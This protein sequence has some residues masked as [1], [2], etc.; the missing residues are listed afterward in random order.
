MKWSEGEIKILKDGYENGKPPEKIAEELGRS[1]RAVISKASVMGISN[2]MRV[3]TEE[4]AKKLKEWYEVHTDSLDLELLSVEMGRTMPFL[5]RQAKK[6]GLTKFGRKPKQSLTESAE[7]LKRFDSKNPE[8][9]YEALKKAQQRNK[10]NPPIIPKRVYT[11]E[12][13]KKASARVKA[14]WQDPTSAFNSQAYKTKRSKIQSE[15]MRSRIK[16]NAENYSRGRGGRRKDLNNRYFRSSW[17]AN[18]ARY[19]NFLIKNGNIFKW[20]YEPDTFY[21]EKIKRGTRS[22]TP[23]F[24]IWEKIDSDPYYVEIKGWMDDKSKT[25][26][27]RMQKY[28]PYIEI[29]LFQEREYKELKN[30]L[31]KMLFFE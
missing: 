25:K 12:E 10:E 27:K 21:F 23:D 19:L 20:E 11:E 2:D 16:T 1:K 31:G 15:I 26:L 7:R 29:R 13:K 5:C 17:E 30:K 4:E 9:K 18:Y 28:Y 22:Y 24:K 14:M 6:L 8:H 3:F